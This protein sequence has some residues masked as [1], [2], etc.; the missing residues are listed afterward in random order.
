MKISKAI[1]KTW[2]FSKCEKEVI[3]LSCCFIFSKLKFYRSLLIQNEFPYPSY[4]TYPAPKFESCP[5]S[6]LHYLW[7]SCHKCFM[8]WFYFSFF[9]HV[10]YSLFHLDIFTPLLLNCQIKFWNFGTKTFTKYD[11]LNSKSPIVLFNFHLF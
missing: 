4:F 7:C 8:P 9:Y 1:K 11:H 10:I 3:L 5:F 6:N 2:F